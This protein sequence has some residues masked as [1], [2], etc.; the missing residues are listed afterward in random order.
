[1]PLQLEEA[2][3]EEFL[4]ICAGLFEAFED[5]YEPYLRFAAPIFN[6]DRQASLQGFADRSLQRSKARGAVWVKIVD[7]DADN[8]IVAAANWEFHTENSE[9]D[10]KPAEPFQAE[11]WPEG[12]ARE[13]ATQVILK[14]A[15][16]ALSQA[17]RPYACMCLCFYSVYPPCPLPRLPSTGPVKP[18]LMNHVLTPYHSPQYHFHDSQLPPSRRCPASHRLGSEESRYLGSAG[19]GAILGDGTPPIREVRLHP[20]Q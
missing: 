10:A 1:M 16:G 7:T 4:E 13:F 14:V 8:K 12:V 3:D 2:K 20:C 18:R 19:L 11:W 6:D 5:P 9:P 15:G 17:Q